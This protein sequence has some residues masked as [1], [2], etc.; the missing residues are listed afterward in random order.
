MLRDRLLDRVP[1]EKF[2]PDA[3]SPNDAKIPI[4][5]LMPGSNN[6]EISIDHLG[7]AVKSI[8]NALRFYEMQLSLKSVS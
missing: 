6:T 1:A 8:D 3:T 5:F 4:Q 2:A 7:I